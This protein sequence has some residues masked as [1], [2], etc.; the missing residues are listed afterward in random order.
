MHGKRGQLCIIFIY[1]LI[2]IIVHQKQKQVRKAVTIAG[3]IDEMK[4]NLSD[5][6]YTSFKAALGTYH[7]V[8]TG[9]AA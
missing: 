8:C 3:F 2:L 6:A 4:S 9:D 1:S 7:Q 5:Q